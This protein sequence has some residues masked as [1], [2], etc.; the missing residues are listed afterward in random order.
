MGTTKNDIGLFL[1]REGFRPEETE[2]GFVFEYENLTYFIFWDDDDDQYL[3]VALPGIFNVDE[4]NR[5][6]TLVAANEVNMEWKVI[7]AL[8]TSDDVWVVAEQLV[9]KDPTL[10][11]L[12]PRIIQILG[13]ARLSFYE[14]LKEL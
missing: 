11:D 12:I 8:V 9:D 6:D 1:K 5:D 3:K 4:N 2:F 7:K 13:Q 14:H 10:S